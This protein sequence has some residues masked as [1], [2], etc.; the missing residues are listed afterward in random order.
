MRRSLPGRR[1]RRKIIT[2]LLNQK[3]FSFEKGFLISFFGEGK[4][5]FFRL[6]RGAGMRP[7]L[8]INA[9]LEK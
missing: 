9:A 8:W 3:P 2:L 5:Q 1:N 4:N 6:L 7:P